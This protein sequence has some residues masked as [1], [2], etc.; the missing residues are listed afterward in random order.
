MQRFEA[1]RNPVARARSACVRGPPF[2]LR[3]HFGLHS[4]RRGQAVGMRL[5]ARAVVTPID[6]PSSSTLEPHPLM[7]FLR[8]HWGK[9]LALVLLLAAGVGGYFYSRPPRVELVSVTRHEVVQT[10]VASGRVMP[11]AR[12]ELAALS[13]GRVVSVA[14]RE[15]ERVEAGAVLA[16][17]DDAEA[18]A[19]LARAEA[20]ALAARARLSRIR[21]PTAATA[22]EA[23]RRAETDLGAARLDLDRLEQVALAGGVT[24]EEVGDAR[25]ALARS[26]SE[27]ETA[28]ITLSGARGVDG[29]EA[30]ATLT[31]A[32]ADVTA[33]RIRLSN[34]TIVAPAPGVLVSS[35]VEPGAVVSAG[36]I[37]FELAVD[38]PT[39][40]RI[41][42]DESTLALIQL[43][44]SALVGPE[45]FPELRLPAR[46]SYLAPA[47]DALRG[48]IEVRLEVPDPPDELRADMTVSVDVE[49]ARRADALVLPAGAVRAV[50]TTEPWVMMAEGG[51][52]VRREVQIGAIG[53]ESIE[54]LD[55]V[56]E[57][58][59][60]I[61]SNATVAVGAR[62][63]VD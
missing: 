4:M 29:R 3:L 12:V 50:G 48:T 16:Q 31:Q 57:G 7:A 43:G 53:E 27:R 11:A 56:R 60:V 54:I 38:G 9:L 59:R 35:A 19:A 58:E 13:L 26:E 24:A 36:Q 42:P 5:A 37:L 47:V 25:N 28:R 15:G 40:V 22:A 39:R 1:S 8:R 44:Q 33:A 32:E 46:V 34:L 30:A 17:L 49:V 20:V 63:R 23:L 51:R 2:E 41:D 6:V 18:Q 14:H 61:P 10:V 55:G 62:V 45:A 21:G 52:T